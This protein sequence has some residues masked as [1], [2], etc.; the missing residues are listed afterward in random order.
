LRQG[1]LRLPANEKPAASAAGFFMAA[2]TDYYS[3]Y[4]MP[5]IHLTNSILS[6]RRIALNITN[7]FISM[8]EIIHSS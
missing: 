8:A 3:G 2:C 1:Q 6:D 5:L 4:C 7:Y